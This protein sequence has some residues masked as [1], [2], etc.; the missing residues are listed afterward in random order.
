MI[1]SPHDLPAF[2]ELLADGSPWGIRIDYAVQHRPE[3]IAQ[4][5]ILGEA[6][7]AGAPCSLILGDNIFYGQDFVPRLRRAAALEHGARIFA[8]HVNDPERFGVV[9]M[10]SDF[11]ALSIEEKPRNPKSSW[12]VEYAKTLKPSARGELEITALNQIYLEAGTLA[13]SPLGRGF[14]WLDT[15][16]HESLLE[17]GMFI[18]TIQKRQGYMIACLEEIALQNGWI[19][20][21]RVREAARS[22][23]G[24]AYGRY[25]KDLAE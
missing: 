25:L 24:T 7:I 16:T 14:A 8:Y 3:G 23:G 12:A 19:D 5:L 11:A 21:V 17:A 4:A 18:S 6:F 15:G 22:Y 9:E 10:D 2:Q 13:V 1:S 20:K